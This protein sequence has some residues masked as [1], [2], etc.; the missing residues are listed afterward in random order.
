MRKRI[1][2]N[3]CAYY[4]PERT[5]AEYVCTSY[6]THVIVEYDEVDVLSCLSADLHRFMIILSRAFNIQK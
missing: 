3:L 5:H 4:K 2:L 1:L 6:N